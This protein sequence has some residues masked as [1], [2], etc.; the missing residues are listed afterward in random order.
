MATPNVARGLVMIEM[1][2]GIAIGAA[3]TWLMAQRVGN[4]RSLPTGCGHELECFQCHEPVDQS[5]ELCHGC[6]EPLAQ[7]VQA[8]LSRLDD[9]NQLIESMA[10]QNPSLALSHV[11]DDIIRR[12]LD[13]LGW[14]APE[15]IPLKA[16][17]T[18]VGNGHAGTFV[19]H[20]AL[21]LLTMVAGF[22]SFWMIKTP[23]FFVLAPVFAL[24]GL[25]VGVLLASCWRLRPAW[26]APVCFGLLLSHAA[27]A[28]LNIVGRTEI[29]RQ[30][31]AALT[32]PPVWGA[33]A[34]TGMAWMALAWRDAFRL[35]TG[36]ACAL[37]GCAAVFAAAWFHAR[38]LEESLPA[39]I[40]AGIGYMA[41]LPMILRI[42]VGGGSRSLLLDRV[43]HAA[44]M[45]CATLWTGA[46]YKGT[47]LG[48]LACLAGAM[49]VVTTLRSVIWQSHGW[50][51]VG[52]VCGLCA[53]VSAAKAIDMSTGMALVASAGWIGISAS[54]V[55]LISTRWS[56]KHRFWNQCTAT[57]GLAIMCVPALISW[58]DSLFPAGSEWM[59]AWRVACASPL[60]LLALGSSSLAALLAWMPQGQR[61]IDCVITTVWFLFAGWA[62]N[63]GIVPAVGVLAGGSL[64]MACHAGRNQLLL[65][66]ILSSISTVVTLG[67]ECR[68]PGVWILPLQLFGSMG[69]VAGLLLGYR[70]GVS[71][72]W[73]SA[74][75]VV[76]LAIAAAGGIQTSASSVLVAVSAGWAGLGLV[77]RL[78]KFAE[79]EDNPGSPRLHVIIGSFLTGMVAWII[80]L[81]LDGNPWF[82]AAGMTS[83]LVLMGAASR[84]DDLC[85]RQMLFIT[86]SFLLACFTGSMISIALVD[87]VNGIAVPLLA[88]VW[89][90]PAL[91]ATIGMLMLTGNDISRPVLICAR[92]AGIFLPLLAC[93]YSE[94][95]PLARFAMAWGAISWAAVS[96][97]ISMDMDRRRQVS[98]ISWRGNAVLSL[99]LMLAA[100]GWALPDPVQDGSFLARGSLATLGL[101][102]GFIVSNGIESGYLAVSWL[103]RR[104]CRS[105]LERI[106]L[107]STGALSV[108]L[109][110]EALMYRNSADPAW[111]GL[112][113]AVGLAV[114]FMLAGAARLLKTSAANPWWIVSMAI[115]LF[116]HLSWTSTRGPQENT[117]L[118]FLMAGCL[119][120]LGGVVHV[121]GH[122][123]GPAFRTAGMGLVGVLIGLCLLETRGTP[124]DGP[125]R[126]FL[127]GGL[128]L[129]EQGARGINVVLMLSG[130]LVVAGLTGGTRRACSAGACLALAA[131]VARQA[132]DG[133]SWEAIM[134]QALAVAALMTSLVRRDSGAASEGAVPEVRESRAA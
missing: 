67:L 87:W 68:E 20:L 17:H 34:V 59:V 6:G 92:I 66:A 15:A 74:V 55:S 111:A 65:P 25:S 30:W 12:R 56:V 91:A 127:Q 88:L 49:V 100:C 43:L 83:G 16:S 41:F 101:C 110:M 109:L 113:G 62:V 72:C 45:A 24:A 18:A 126:A 11:L 46:F 37:A 40:W 47:P 57:A 79:K 71:W 70:G 76:P 14:R 31:L 125:H 99:V 4:R 80:S 98:A 89:S 27:M 81:G 133:Q 86:G 134:P 13:L 103:T 21:L 33:I 9:A 129:V 60:F 29:E 64:I 108:C 119:I 112:L 102:I 107:I 28:L 117:G 38:D 73:M 10:R 96:W 128:P 5:H 63:F 53:V 93:T 32:G 97:L 95:L 131:S 121:F 105:S 120:G 69:V 8:E 22:G 52:A 54:F 122:L 23:P 36:S 3:A 35:T 48:Q 75:A 51:V 50:A 39:L 1:G 2:L 106:E 130:I 118:L 61:A 123:S 104:A 78:W 132:L 114:A 7:V 58:A 19:H 85:R 94:S 42:T 116:L 44:L 115:G 90:G 84:L 26:A 82:I 124:E 77:L